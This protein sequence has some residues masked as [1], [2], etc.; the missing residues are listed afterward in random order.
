[1]PAAL[2]E[3]AGTFN[4]MVDIKL[5]QWADRELAHTS[6]QV[7]ALSNYFIIIY[8]NKFYLTLIWY[9]SG[10][11]GDAERFIPSAGGSECEERI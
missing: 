11:L 1:M 9:I 4:T 5:K 3:T 6:I 8:V 10:W 2:V 7:T